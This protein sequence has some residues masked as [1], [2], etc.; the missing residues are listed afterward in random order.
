MI[1]RRT[2]RAEN[3]EVGQ[4]VV[5]AGGRR[6]DVVEVIKY[7]NPDNGFLIVFYRTRHGNERTT[8]HSTVAGVLKYVAA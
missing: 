6:F 2:I 4:V 1:A 7:R 5:D 8:G 3:L